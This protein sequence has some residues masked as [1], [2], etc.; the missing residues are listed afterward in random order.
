MCG[1]TGQDAQGQCLDWP[2]HPEDPTGV[3]GMDSDCNHAIDQGV[4]CYDDARPSQTK[5]PNCQG[6]GAVSGCGG[7]LM[8]DTGGNNAANGFQPVVFGC[9]DYY[10]T[11]CVYDVS[12]M[13]G[14]GQQGAAYSRA[15]REFAQCA[16]R[17][18]QPIGYCH[19]SIMTAA[20]LSNQAVCSQGSTLNI[21]FHVSSLSNLPLLVTTRT[22]SDRLLVVTDPHPFPRSPGRHV[23]VPDGN[24]E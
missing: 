17:S 3:A 18:P 8:T 5:L 12:N 7:Q 13:Q 4:I 10:T 19:G 9:I 20:Q 24:F 21:G 15:L 16:D 2:G 6:C 11:Q 1:A 14:S 23:H 22:F